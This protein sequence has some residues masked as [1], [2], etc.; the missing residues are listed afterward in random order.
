MN[1][2]HLLEVIA[3]RPGLRF[4][5]LAPN[6][7]ATATLHRRALRLPERLCRRWC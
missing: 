2:K 5:T 3:V 6:S 7:Q 4:D 1:E